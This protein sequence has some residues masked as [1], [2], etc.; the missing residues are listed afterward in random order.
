MHKKLLA[1]VT[2]LLALAF[3]A[4][5][6]VPTVVS[7]NQFGE[8]STNYIIGGSNQLDINFKVDSTNANGLGISELNG[9]AAAAVYMHTTQTPAVGNPNPASGYVIVKFAK[10][11]T[12]Y[13]SGY[14][15]YVVPNSGSNIVASTTGVT[16]GL[17]YVITS[18]GTTPSTQ[19]QVLGF[20]ASETPAVG[21][22]FIASATTTATGTGIVQVPVASGSNMN[23]IE[24]VGNGST[25]V[26]ASTGGGQLILVNLAATNASVTTLAAKAPN[27]G[28]RI[29]LRFTMGTIPAGF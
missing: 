6:A 8:Q 18:L 7:K 27:D 9:A 15:A 4:Q 3:T 19:W 14:E 13:I 11:Y 23:H 12:G 28:S 10:S 2:L 22:A 29:K 24:I 25:T 21:A 20:P 26:S 5:A 1:T 16:S 17:A